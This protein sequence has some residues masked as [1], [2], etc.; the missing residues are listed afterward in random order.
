M[1]KVQEKSGRGGNINALFDIGWHLNYFPIAVKRHYDQDK[2]LNNVFNLELR[3]S[4][5]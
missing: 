4:K 3:I 1:F 5:D 2:L